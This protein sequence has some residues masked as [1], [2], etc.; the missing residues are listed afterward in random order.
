MIPNVLRGGL[1]G[2]GAVANDSHLPAWRLEHNVGIVAICDLNP[3]MARKTALRW[4]IRNTYKDSSEMLENEKLDFVDICTPPQTHLQIA[5]EAIAAGQHVLLEKPMTINSREANELV[6]VS[7]GSSTK[8]C[9]V[10]HALFYPVFNT[11][12]SM[13]DSG[14]IGDLV[15]VDVNLRVP[16]A[17]ITDQNHWYYS[18]PGGMLGEHAPHPVYLLRALLGEIQVIKTASSKCGHFDWIPLDELKVLV[19]AEKGIGSFSVSLNA[20]VFSFT[21]DIT[22]TKETIHVDFV[23]Q[24]LNR[25]LPR[26]NRTYGLILRHFDANWQTSASTVSVLKTSLLGDK[27]YKAAH[28]RLIQKFVASIQNNLPSPV[29]PQQGAETVKILEQIWSQIG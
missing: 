11:A 16:R 9:V 5:S 18:M 1:I 8:L 26:P 20:P 27:W 2:C 4:G 7:N 12:K 14:R 6:Q 28:R 21:V 23:T 17:R 29:P 13:I 22:G 10:H 15:S 19:K 25:I 3:E 24:T